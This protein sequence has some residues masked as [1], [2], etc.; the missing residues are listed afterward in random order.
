MNLK[1][2]SKDQLVYNLLKKGLD[3][4][5]LRTKAISNNI[6]NINTKG[7]KRQ[8]VSF[9]ESLKENMDNLNLKTEDDK[10]IQEGSEYGQIKTAV[11]ESSSMREDGNNVDPE[12]EMANEAANTL[13]YNAL[14]TQTN[15]RLSMERYVIN[16]R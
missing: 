11:D 3:A 1:S 8:Y 13:M 9:E 6:A 10:H 7:Y 14:I 15:S 12:N 4:S 2:L 16:G 5:S